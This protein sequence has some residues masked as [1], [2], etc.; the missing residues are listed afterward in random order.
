MVMRKNGCIVP[1]EGEP[2]PTYISFAEEDKN[3]YAHGVNIG[4][5]VDARAQKI[6]IMCICLVVLYAVALI[7]PTDMLSPSF[8][9]MNGNSWYYSLADFVADVSENVN[10]V[11][12]VFSGHFSDVGASTQY[13]VRLAVVA[14]AGAGLALSGAVYQGSFRNA[15]VSPST[16]GVMN[17]SKLGLTVFVLLFMT[18]E[19]TEFPWTG[20]IYS[21]DNFPT[22]LAETA[23]FLYGLSLFAFVGCV[24]VV[25]LVLVTMKFA[26][27]NSGSSILV[28]LCGQVIGGII[29]AVNQ[30]IRYYILATEGEYS[31][32]YE[33][34]TQLTTAS[35]WNSYTWI[36]IF[37]IFLPL[38]ITFL[39]V[40]RV[41]SRM[42]L[43]SFDKGEARS[44]GV[45]A[46]RMQI[47]VVMLC[48]LLTAIIVSFC[49]TI[50]YVGF[51]VPH[52]ARRMVGPDFKYLLPASTVLG[53]LFVLGAWFLMISTVGGDY[54]SMMGSLISIFRS[55][56]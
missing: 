15:L 9:I 32:K 5:K 55:I 30:N 31:E 45:D 35:F 37:C 22:G 14:L 3:I 56:V 38:L 52:L 7:M 43:L 53:A 25:A 24:F 41:R 8:Y 27:A 51:L 48:T 39:V 29:Q 26:G 34:L 44:M 21:S 19:G 13:M 36:D 20:V 33:L 17:G 40:M 42:Q 54:S 6:F 18:A 47:T 16:L 12:L 50:G 28:V 2:A 4:H 11:M 46:R 10:G 49:G 1:G 23:W